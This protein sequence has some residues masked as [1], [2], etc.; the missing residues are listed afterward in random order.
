MIQI[1]LQWMIIRFGV[2]QSESV[3]VVIVHGP[4]I[5]VSFLVRSSGARWQSDAASS[6]K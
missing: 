6:D 1:G 3:I 4:F 5:L 2:N